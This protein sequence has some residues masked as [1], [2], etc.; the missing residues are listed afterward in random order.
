M[1]NDGLS[2]QQMQDVVSLL[3]DSFEAHLEAEH[4]P[5]HRPVEFEPEPDND[6]ENSPGDIR[7]R[8]A[9]NQPSVVQVTHVCPDASCDGQRCIRADERRVVL[10]RLRDCL[11]NLHHRFGAGET[12]VSLNDVVTV[13]GEIGEEC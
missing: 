8:R 13:I 9:A 5:Q 10:N 3:R 2:K 4:S 7:V 1:S 11:D 12:W 6:D